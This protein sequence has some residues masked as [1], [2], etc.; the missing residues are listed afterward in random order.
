MGGGVVARFA[1][2][3]EPGKAPWLENRTGSLLCFQLS[4]ELG[5][6]LLQDDRQ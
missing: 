3:L 1:C 5:L 6:V 4:A 2:G